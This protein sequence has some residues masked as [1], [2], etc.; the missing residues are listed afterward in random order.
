MKAL[1][2]YKNQSVR[3][4]DVEASTQYLEEPVPGP[5]RQAWESEEEFAIRYEREKKV[6]RFEGVLIKGKDLE[7]FVLFIEE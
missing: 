7:E 2:V 4:T 3:W 1:L 5:Y 6:I